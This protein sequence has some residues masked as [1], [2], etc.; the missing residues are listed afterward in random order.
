MSFGG[1]AGD[2]YAGLAFDRL[3]AAGIGAE[4]AGAEAER[5]IRGRAA[6]VTEVLFEIL[7]GALVNV[8]VFVQFLARLARFEF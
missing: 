4:E 1:A 3:D 5:V 8:A 7:V 2:G 6:E